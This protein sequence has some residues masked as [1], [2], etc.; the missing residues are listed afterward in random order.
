M[1]FIDVW[2]I[3]LFIFKNN[4]SSLHHELKKYEISQTVGRCCQG[5]SC[6]A[7]L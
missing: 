1:Q 6:I 2:D 4:F 7:D 5:V 3:T